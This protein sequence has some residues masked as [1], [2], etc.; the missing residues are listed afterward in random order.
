MIEPLLLIIT[1]FCLGLAVGSFLNVVI[2]RGHKGETLQGRSHC[3][4][5]DETL[6]WQEL[7][8]VASFLIQKTRCRHCKAKISWQYPLVELACAI[9]YVA[10]FWTLVSEGMRVNAQPL[11]F[12]GLAIGIPA[13]LV[14]LVSD[15]RF[16]TI[17]DGATLTLGIIGLGAVIV[18]SAAIPM[19]TIRVAPYDLGTALL[20]AGILGGLWFFSAGQWM[21]FG[22]VKLIFA[23]SLILGFPAAIAA[24]LFAFWSGGI[25]GAL[26]LLTR[27]K[28]LRQQIPFGPF[29]I[30]GGILAWF[31][32]PLFFNSLGLGILV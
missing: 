18:R 11:A 2:I 16:Q 27:K 4:R 6:S 17:P 12:A 14:I 10:G 5:C 28:Q 21:G 31:F 15:L 32:S 26:L 20:A 3:A 19:G 24:C 30:L 29:I 9:A 1:I 23:T 8:P 13:V 22:D 25:I 7:V